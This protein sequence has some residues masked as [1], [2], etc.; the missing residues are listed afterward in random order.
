MMQTSRIAGSSI[1]ASAR[2]RASVKLSKN[3]F[4]H[5]PSVVWAIICHG[6][7]VDGDGGSF[8]DRRK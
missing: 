7:D 1:I 5:F 8:T 2:A 3:P 4:F 6:G